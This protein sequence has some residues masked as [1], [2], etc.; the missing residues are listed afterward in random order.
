MKNVLILTE[1]K[2]AKEKIKEAILNVKCMTIGGYA[3]TLDEE[4]FLSV[5]KEILDNSICVNYK[6]KNGTKEPVYI[7]NSQL[8]HDNCQEILNFLKENN[9]NIIVNACEY[10]KNGDYLFK[11]AVEDVMKL[12]NNKAYTFKRMNML[13]I[14]KESFVS[15]YNSI[16][17]K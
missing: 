12:N 14:T 15:A 9:I 17:N 16:F 1:K 11:Y 4:K 7:L 13:G 5:S 6:D 10:D 8:V 2:Y 3:Y